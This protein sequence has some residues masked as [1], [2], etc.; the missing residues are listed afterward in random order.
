MAV[1]A[2]RKVARRG[3]RNNP[4]PVF[5]GCDKLSGPDFLDLQ[6]KATNY[7]R[8]EY[9]T[10]DLY[11][12]WHKW[13]ANNEYTKQQISHIKKYNKDT[14]VVGIY[15]RCIN[16]GMVDYHEEAARHWESL[17]G[18]AGQMKP[19]S[20]FLHKTAKRLLER[21][22][23][24]EQDDDDDEAAKKKE[25]AKKP[26]IQDHLREKTYDTLGELE[27][28]YD[29]YIAN[30]SKTEKGM[31]K[32]FNI[33]HNSNLGP[34]FINM[35]V[36]HWTLVLDELKELQAGTC[37]QLNECYRH[38]GKIQVRNNIKFCE[39]VIAD[40]GS[41]LQRKKANRTPR[42]RKPVSPEKLIRSF[43]YL[44]EDTALGIKSSKVT[45]LVDAG[46]A[47]FYD[48][49]KRKLIYVVADTYSKTFSVKGASLIGIDTTK[50]VQKTLR[51]PAEQIKEFMKMSVPNRR[52]FFQDLKSV[53]I[54]YTGRSNENLLLLAIR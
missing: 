45:D 54:K 12:D 16:T 47:W 46:E 22:D 4:D 7:Y 29:Q 13:L 30:D 28:L 8:T 24:V 19:T 1:K 52:K 50:T 2:K 6:R 41:Y 49:K 9:K 43:K 23:E 27:D 3:K 37:E 10:K 21:N 15:A 35:I 40:C 26:N 17:P 39:Q 31:Q 32:P 5:E 14:G 18:T 53:E 38:W 20:E 11:S 36:T 25:A 33:I 44:K 34:Q 51:K 42:K 48:T